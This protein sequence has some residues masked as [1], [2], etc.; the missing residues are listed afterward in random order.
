MLNFTEK[1]F[2]NDEDG[3][4]IVD[5]VVLSNRGLGMAVLHLLAVAQPYPWRQGQF[6]LSAADRNILIQTPF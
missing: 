2:R 3:A 5:W 1:N 4:V 6:S